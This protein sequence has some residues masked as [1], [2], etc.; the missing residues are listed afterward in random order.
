VNVRPERCGINQNPIPK[1][2]I[3]TTV[4]I[5][6][7]KC[8][9]TQIVLWTTAFIWWDALMI[10]PA[11]PGINASIPI[12]GARKRTSFHGKRSEEH[13]SELQSRFD[14]VCRLLLEKKKQL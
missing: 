9:V 4:A 2:V 11:P 1:N 5:V 13:T 8:P 7:W 6:K 14:L 12:N 10:P 3:I